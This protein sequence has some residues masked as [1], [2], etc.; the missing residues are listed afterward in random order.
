MFSYARN[1]K[2]LHVT[3]DMDNYDLTIQHQIY[4]RRQDAGFCLTPVP[5]DM[6][7]KVSNNLSHWM[8]DNHRR[9]LLKDSETELLVYGYTKSIEK[10]HKNDN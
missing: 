1:L 10:S 5:D 2:Y 4:M 8:V 7:K 3:L 9:E 6:M